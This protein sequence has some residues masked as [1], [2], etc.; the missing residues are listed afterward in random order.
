MSA[1]VISGTDIS[2]VIR[3]EVATGVA[4]LKAEGVNPTSAVVLVGADG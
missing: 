3:D 2:Q 4:E 1:R